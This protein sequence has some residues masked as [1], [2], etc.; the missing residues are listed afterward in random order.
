MEKDELLIALQVK[1]DRLMEALETSIRQG[2]PSFYSLDTHEYLGEVHMYHTSKLKREVVLPMLRDKWISKDKCL[3]LET[4][5]AT[6]NNKWPINSH[7]FYSMDYLTGEAPGFLRFGYAICE[8]ELFPCAFFVQMTMT[9]KI[10]EIPGELFPEEFV[11]DPMAL[12]CGKRPDC[13]IGV[14]VPLSLV[15]KWLLSRSTEKHP[16]ETYVKEHNKERTEDSAWEKEILQGQQEMFQNTPEENK[17]SVL[18]WL[19]N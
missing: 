14:E 7:Y 16:L 2:K 5:Y 4:F 3:K 6:N 9:Q 18:R 10:E 19:C 15:E 1:A 12:A 13:Y 8:G 17:E 11:I